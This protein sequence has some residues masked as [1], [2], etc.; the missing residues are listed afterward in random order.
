MELNGVTFYQHFAECFYR[1]ISCIILT[2]LLLVVYVF[3]VVVVVATVVR[4]HYFR[5][6]QKK[7][8]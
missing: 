6:L 7:F 4:V 8:I 5:F 1:L 2:F 3:V